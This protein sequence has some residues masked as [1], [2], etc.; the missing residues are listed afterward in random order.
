MALWIIGNLLTVFTLSAVWLS[1]PTDGAIGGFTKSQLISYYLFVLILNW[2]VV[3]HAAHYV[4]EE[5]KDGSIG[6]KVLTKPI[7]YYLKNLFHEMGWHSISPIAGLVS[8]AIAL[9]FLHPYVEINLSLTQVAFLIPAIFMGGVI[10]FSISLCLGMLAFWFTETES[11]HT[12]LWIGLFML[13]GQ[14]IPLSFYPQNI[15]NILL[16]LPFAYIFYLPLEIFSGKLTVPQMSQ[17]LLI[18]IIW[19][20]IFIFIYKFMWA[21]GTRAYQSYGG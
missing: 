7:S 17:G 11:L 20:A 12:L 9:V 2:L 4:K 19:I 8:L 1:V 5:I 18:Q 15:Q 21:K 3:W 14:G 13:G 6:Q 16:L 10:C